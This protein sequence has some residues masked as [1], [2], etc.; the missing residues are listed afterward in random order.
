MSWL[1]IKK[2][3]FCYGP[4]CECFRFGSGFMILVFVSFLVLLRKRQLVALL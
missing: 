2:I 1:R 3:N 4:V